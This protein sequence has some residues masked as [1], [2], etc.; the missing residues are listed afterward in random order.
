VPN[1]RR[2]RHEG[3]QLYLFGRLCVLVQD[4]VLFVEQEGDAVGGGAGGG[5]KRKRR[6]AFEPIGLEQLL[7]RVGVAQKK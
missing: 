1:I 7:E 5:G 2:G 6:A 4:G 3:Q